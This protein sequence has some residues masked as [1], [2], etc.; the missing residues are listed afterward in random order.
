MFET[1]YPKYVAGCNGAELVNFVMEDLGLPEYT[2]P[3]EFYADK[4][5]EYW[6]GWVLAY[7]QWKKR[8]SFH[9]ILQKVPVEKILG[10][11][12][13]GHEQDVRNV[14]DLLSEWMGA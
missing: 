13:T 6:A 7:F 1:G 8:L 14:A 12:P 10:L 5:P 11:Y 4:S 9:S 3:Q 2:C